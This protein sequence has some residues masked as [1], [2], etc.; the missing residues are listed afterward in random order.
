[1]QCSPVRASLCGTHP[2][3]L[4]AAT[5]DNDGQSPLWPFS[6]AERG[7]AI[8]EGGAKT[9]IG[10]G[11]GEGEWVQKWGRNNN[12]DKYDAYNVGRSIQANACIIKSSTMSLTTL[13]LYQIVLKYMF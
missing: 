13:I 11:G 1:M 5:K 4:H 10:G 7:G 6:S 3:L 8:E 9:M 12:D 2:E